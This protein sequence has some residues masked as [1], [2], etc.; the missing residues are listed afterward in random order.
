MRTERSS[1]IQYDI[2]KLQDTGC[3]IINGKVYNDKGHPICGVLN[4]HDKP[5]RRIGKCPFHGETRPVTRENSTNGTVDANG[6]ALP[7]VRS[8]PDHPSRLNPSS[9]STSRAVN[10]RPPKK[11]QYKH[12]WTKEEHYLF[13][14][15]LETYERGNWKKISQMVGTRSATQVQSHAQKFFLRQKQRDK[16][17]RSIHDQTMDSPDMKELDRLFNQRRFPANSV[18]GTASAGTVAGTG[19]LGT[20]GEAIPQNLFN[21]AYEMTAGGG[22]DG[23]SLHRGREMAPLFGTVGIGNTAASASRGSSFN[24]GDNVVASFVGS[25]S[26][27]AS[28]Y[29]PGQQVSNTS[30]GPALPSSM[31]SAVGGVQQASGVSNGTVASNF[32]KSGMSVGFPSRSRDVPSR[33]VEQ[34]DLS[35]YH[36]QRAKSQTQSGSGGIG[37]SPYSSKPDHRILDPVIVTSNNV[38]DNDTHVAGHDNT[39]QTA[40]TNLYGGGG[41]HSVYSPGNGA[42]SR[43][44]TSGQH[45]PTDG[46]RVNGDQRAV[47]GYG[48][49]SFNRRSGN[50]MTNAGYAHSSRDGFVQSPFTAIGSLPMADGFAS[51]GPISGV[52]PEHHVD[53]G[54]DQGPIHQSSAFT[55]GSPSFANGVSTGNGNPTPTFGSTQAQTL[56]SHQATNFGSG[57][58]TGTYDVGDASQSFGLNA[59]PNSGSMQGIMNG[60]AANGLHIPGVGRVGVRGQSGA[61]HSLGRN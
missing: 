10:A 23:I 46:P 29:G 31:S 37:M 60:L 61:N 41:L 16:N 43:V 24:A 38:A 49:D 40:S 48:G 20:G 15:G 3:Q 44:I 50:A 27:P 55:N 53:G 57:L 30:F 54:L 45:Y 8:N 35:S 28:S 22:Q 52:D 1:Y 51:V 17:K 11:Q 14:R 18:G 21:N 5:C 39:A 9:G 36:N 34:P 19:P 4:Q 2:G 47:V 32:Q 25:A 7:C 13:L 59:A 42:S 58:L 56:A 33:R 12:G 6:T 26:N